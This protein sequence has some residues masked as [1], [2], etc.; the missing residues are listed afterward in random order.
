MYDETMTQQRRSFLRASLLA[1]AALPMRGLPIEDADAKKKAPRKQISVAQRANNMIDICFRE[2]GDPDVTI[3]SGSTSVNC[4]FSDGTGRTCTYTKNSSK[5]QTN[6]AGSDQPG[7]EPD[8]PTVDPGDVPTFPLEP[9][10]QTSNAGDAP[11]VP[12][13][14]DG[15]LRSSI[16]GANANRRRA[17]R[18]HR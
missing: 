1:L 16:S 11:T 17:H 3:K 7:F 12:L 9:D 8:R 5:C 18:R 4:T 6:A 13:E 2:G 14:P 10:T 15:D